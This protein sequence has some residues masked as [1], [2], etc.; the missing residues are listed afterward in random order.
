MTAPIYTRA[1]ATAIKQLG[2]AP[3]GKGSTLTL[4][5]VTSGG[6]YVPGGGESAPTVTTYM[7]SGIRTAYRLQDV[8]GTLVQATDVRFI[9]SPVLQSGGDMPTPKPS[10]TLMFGGKVYNVIDCKPWDFDGVTPIGFV[11]Q[12][13]E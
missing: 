1:R 2:L 6:D 4:N 7:G 12:A 9:V 11:V 3:T 8:D 10:D 13:R 5:R